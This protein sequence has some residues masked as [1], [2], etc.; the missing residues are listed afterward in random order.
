[1]SNPPKDNIEENFPKCPVC[2]ELVYPNSALESIVTDAA[3]INFFIHT[4][5]IDSFK[6]GMIN[7]NTNP[8]LADKFDDEKLRMDLLPMR[9]IEDIAA[10]LTYGAKKYKPNNWRKGMR[11][12]KAFAAAL[13]HLWAWWK[14]EDNDKESGLSHLAHAATEILFLL[15]YGRT[16]KELDDR[17]KE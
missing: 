12:G 13:R 10:V 8:D 4:T 7:V 5:C 2:H 17:V 9:P 6:Q 15:E 1:M 3:G 11:W 16:H 14:G